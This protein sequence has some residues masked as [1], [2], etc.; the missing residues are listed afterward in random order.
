M[1]EMV[2]NE[3]SVTYWFYGQCTYEFLSYPSAQS[4]DVVWSY[5]SD[6]LLDMGFL[7]Q[8]N[9]VAKYPKTSEVF[10]TLTRQDDNTLIATYQYPEWVKKVNEIA[11]D[12]IF[13]TQYFLKEEK[14]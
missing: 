6:C 5:R 12:S 8:S 10:A 11:K 4:V 7:S 9:G 3:E 2:L 1:C 13:P 14:N